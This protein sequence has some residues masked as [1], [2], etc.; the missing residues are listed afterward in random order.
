MACFESSCGQVLENLE[1][2]EYGLFLAEQ[3]GFEPA[4]GY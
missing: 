1:F 3:A 2:H 4:V